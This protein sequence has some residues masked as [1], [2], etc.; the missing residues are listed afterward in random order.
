MSAGKGTSPM[1]GSAPASNRQAVKETGVSVGNLMT[2]DESQI[3]S[4]TTTTSNVKKALI[5]CRKNCGKHLSL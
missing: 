2:E 3:S 4:Y 1:F 5:V